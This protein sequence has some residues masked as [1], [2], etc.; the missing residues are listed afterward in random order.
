MGRKGQYTHKLYHLDSKVPYFIRMIAPE[1]S[2]VLKEEA[3]NAYP[4]CKTVSKCIFRLNPD[5]FQNFHFQ[6]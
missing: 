4:Y 1:G 5:K 2:L 3:W 6:A